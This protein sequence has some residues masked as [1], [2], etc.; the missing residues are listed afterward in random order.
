MAKNEKAVYAPGELD[1][2]RKKLG[3]NN[4][5]EAKRM[6][7]LL[8]GEVGVE[9]S[10]ESPPPGKI[11]TGGSGGNQRPKHRVE[12]ASDEEVEFIHEA[13]A[14]R[15]ADPADDPLIPVKA[16][17]FER[18]KMDRFCALPE[19]K[20]KSAGQAFIVMLSFFSD[21]SDLANPSF[22]TKKL[23]GYYKILERLVTSVR[24][25][26][27]RNNTKRNE[28]LRRA[29]PFAYSVFD[30]LRYWNLEKIAAGIARVQSHPRSVKITEL[31]DIL[32]NIYRPLFVLERLEV[33]EHI[34]GSFKLLYKILYLENPMNAR[35]KYQGLIRDALVA[36]NDVRRDLHYYLYPLLMKLLSDRYLAYDVFFSARRNRFMN[37]I[38]A[39]ESDQIDPAGMAAEL[40][41]GKELELDNEGE[42]EE[43]D[44]QETPEENKDGPKEEDPDDP[45]IIERKEK[46]AVQEKEHKAMLQGIASL[47]ALFP[48]AGWERLS[49]FPD[50]YPYFRDVYDLRKGYEL[51]APSDPLLQAAVI[52]R[53]LEDLLLGLRN[54]RF[55]TVVS[56]ENGLIR[57]DE[58]LNAVIGDWQ[59]HVN[60]AIEKE[61]L[62]RLIE[63]CRIIEHSESRVSTYAKRIL[64]ELHWIK[65]LF[66]LPY[67]KF[68]SLFP[69]PLQKKD[70]EAVF[71]AVRS[72]RRSL[73]LVA[74]GIEQANRIG[75]AEKRVPCS[76]IDNP[77][78]TY[79]FAIPN[80]VSTRLDA[81]LPVKRR[82]NA[83]LIFF[84]LAFSTVL[85][86]LLNDE[87]SWAYR[88]RNNTLFR[89]VNGLP[90]FGVDK[91]VDAE[92]IFKESIRQR[93]ESGK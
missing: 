84:S 60:V 2:V 9:R 13:A 65:R 55:G 90:Q 78:E 34:R 4:N 19:F 41:G 20:I 7:K 27:P 93:E 29:S 47:E 56:G 52:I 39:S 38:D 24:T 57:V 14:R 58:T 23:D 76:G 86:H 54:V 37:F 48:H 30:T 43:K 92:A 28:K 63:Y 79:S 62:L 89:T 73:A 64:C 1:Q 87:N 8:G 72:L 12:L 35:E 45:K 15:P 51:I 71:P 18:I 80:P 66:F 25:L 22:I 17:Y 70:V 67:Y 53:I 21:S 75:G 61:Y 10:A 26:F 59:S 36:F 69:P 50:M 46:E 33:D 77:W 82:N 91:H 32:K 85:D 68:D 42:N 74:S 3:V 49:A 31:S 83:T 5:D 88:E 6:A 44:G 11:R 40:K 81:L 16:P